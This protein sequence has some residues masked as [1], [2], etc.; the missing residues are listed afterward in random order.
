[1]KGSKEKRRYVFFMINLVHFIM[2]IQ[3][4]DKN[5]LSE[6][7]HLNV[8]NLIHLTAGSVNFIDN[9]AWAAALIPGSQDRRTGSEVQDCCP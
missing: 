4:G 9:T 7:S 1:M 6:Q 2:H 8:R 5:N 3:K